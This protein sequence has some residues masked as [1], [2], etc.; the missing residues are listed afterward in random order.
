MSQIFIEVAFLLCRAA[1]HAVDLPAVFV[2][3]PWRTHTRPTTLSVSTTAEELL[4]HINA[5]LLHPM[6]LKL[7]VPFSICL[8]KS[9]LH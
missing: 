4:S 3:P 2:F 8:I 5:A 1:E 6:V 7:C 9:R